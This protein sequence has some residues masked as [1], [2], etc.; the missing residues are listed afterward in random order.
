MTDSPD[1]MNG[2]TFMLFN[3]GFCRIDIERAIGLLDFAFLASCKD[4]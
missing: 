1:V 3:G 4:G 2:K